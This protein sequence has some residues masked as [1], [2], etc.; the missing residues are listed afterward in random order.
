MK[1]L[2]PW[3]TEVPSQALQQTLKDLD[4]AFGNFFAGRAAYPAF[5]SKHGAAPNVRWPQGVKVN[6]QALYLPKLGW[7]KV[8]FSRKVVGTIKSATVSHDG[9][10]WHVSLLCVTQHTKPDAPV[11]PALGI[12]LGVEESLALSDGRLVRLPVANQKEEIRKQMLSRRVS[13]CVPGSKRHAKAKKRLLIFRRKLDNRT[14]DARHKLTTKLTKNHG[15]L[16]VEDLA[17]KNLTRSAKGTAESPGTN[18]AA[19]SGLNRVMLG[20]GFGETLRQLRYKA[21]WCG[22]VVLAVNP[23]YTS[24][25]CPACKHVSADNRPTRKSFC[26]VKCGH[27]GHADTI[28]SLNIL[29][30]GLAAHARGGCLCAP[31]ESGTYQKAAIAV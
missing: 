22:S 2:F 14:R 29:A 3:L 5:K 21:E 16:F 20:Q 30:A 6:G 18:V 11:G 15:Q 9:V 25:T 28:A 17:V 4:T 7:V 24:Q 27:S 26:C 12:D 8:R 13:R 23:A 1:S 19:K 10:R 31:V